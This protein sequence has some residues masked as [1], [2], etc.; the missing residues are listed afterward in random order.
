MIQHLSNLLSEAYLK[1][2]DTLCSSCI[3]R[4]TTFRA[5]ESSE[6]GCTRSNWLYSTT[7]LCIHGKTLVSET[8]RRLSDHNRMKCYQ[9]ASLTKT[10]SRNRK[11]IYQKTPRILP[12]STHA[13]DVA[14][15]WLHNLTPPSQE[16]QKVPGLI[17]LTK[18][19]PQKRLTAWHTRPWRCQKVMT[20]LPSSW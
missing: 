6:R 9:P 5:L 12:R 20:R 15:Q 13:I 14:R 18:R 17:H 3:I 10:Y 2:N 16:K 4:I 19:Q 1:C 7:E 11:E 8:L